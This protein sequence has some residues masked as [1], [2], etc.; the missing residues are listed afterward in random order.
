M[1]YSQDQ[2]QQTHE[3]ILE[4]AARR[5]RE[6]GVGNTGLQPLMKALGLT[7]GGFYAHF[8][9]KDALVEEALQHAFTQLTRETEEIANTDDP[10]QTFIR[11]YLS[12]KHR[13]NPGN[14]C[15]LPTVAAELGQ[16]GTPSPSSDKIIRDRLHLIEQNL[17]EDQAQHS[18][19]ILSALV[20]ALVLS[21]SVQSTEF[22]DQILET[23]RGLL[24]ERYG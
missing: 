7:H 22:S 19:L 15:A 17:P 4:E 5:F 21:R 20:G 18:L 6:D 11:R 23:V 14:G 9:S 3:R 13:D 1:R 24:M 12:K 10:L 2:K 16:R 8:A